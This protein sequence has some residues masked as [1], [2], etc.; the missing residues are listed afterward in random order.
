MTAHCQEVDRE[1]DHRYLGMLN[2]GIRVALILHFLFIFLFAWGGIKTLAI[3]NIFSSALYII[4]Y[5]LARR[6]C[7]NILLNGLY[8]LEIPVHAVLATVYV[9]WRGGFHSYILMLAVIFNLKKMSLGAK[10]AITGWLCLTYILLYY[11]LRSADPLVEVEPLFLQ[12]C[13]IGNIVGTF[14]VLSLL[15]HYYSSEASKI[16]EKLKK[17]NSELELLV[18]TDHLTKILN[19][20][21]ILERISNE[22]AIFER[23]GKPFSLIMADIDSFKGINDRYGHECGDFVLVAVSKL[24]NN[25]LRKCDSLARWGGEEFL[26]LLPETDLEAGIMTAERIRETVEREVYIFKGNKLPVTITLG[27]S[28][29]NAG[30]GISGCV[31]EADKAM[32]QGKQKGK[33]CVVPVRNQKRKNNSL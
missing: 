32:Y 6:G 10:M 12:T 1:T 29:Y 30:M 25:A 16:E 2:Y 18:T 17:S 28:A 21:S 19:R 22:I 13:S 27:V 23:Y 9:G 11:F 33:N 15:A 14:I 31:N 5:F 7:N 4:C 8:A 24:I 26:V 3:F 20:R